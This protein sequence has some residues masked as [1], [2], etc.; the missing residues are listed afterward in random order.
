[1]GVPPE[2]TMAAG[3]LSMSLRQR[4]TRLPAVLS[5]GV[6]ELDP[7]AKAVRCLHSLIGVRN[8]LMHIRERTV[9]VRG[10]AIG[11]DATGVSVRIPTPPPNPWRTV[12]LGE[13]EA[14]VVAVREYLE[15]IALSSDD[16]RFHTPMVRR[17]R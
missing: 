8:R 6:F 15:R 5:E 17:V 13:A 10:D 1:M 9:V 4:M 16:L 14:Y 11:G 3:I 2:D 12:S 7:E